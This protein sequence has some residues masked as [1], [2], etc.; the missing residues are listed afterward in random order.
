MFGNSVCH[1]VY[2]FMVYF[3]EELATFLYVV[4]F[5]SPWKFKLILI[6]FELV[7]Q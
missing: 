4:D 5:F 2:K 1:C 3:G 6:I 7:S